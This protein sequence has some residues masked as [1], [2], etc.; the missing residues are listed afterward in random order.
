M[1]WRQSCFSGR[2]SSRNPCAL[3]FFVMIRKL[4]GLLTTMNIMATEWIRKKHDELYGIGMETRYNRFRPKPR[5]SSLVGHLPRVSYVCLV[6]QSLKGRCWGWWWNGGH[7]GQCNRF[8]DICLTTEENP[9][10]PQ[11][12]NRRGHFVAWPVIASNG[13][14][15]LQMKSVELRYL[16]R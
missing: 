12:V 15:F 10:K 5:I 11:L 14:P 6:G 9:G 7:R 4:P 3:N 8:P 2:T 1:S 16:L 13:V